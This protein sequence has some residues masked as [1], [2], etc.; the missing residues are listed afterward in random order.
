M[1]EKDRILTENANKAHH[2]GRIQADFYTPYSKNPIIASFF[3][4]IG[5]ADEL[6]SGVRN[7]YK[8]LKIYSNGEPVLFEDDIFR[9]EIPID[10]IDTT[11]TLPI[12]TDKRP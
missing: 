5:R 6:G 10:S 3:N 7:L 4:N 12:K 9:T 1:I 11:E 2:Y 8:Y